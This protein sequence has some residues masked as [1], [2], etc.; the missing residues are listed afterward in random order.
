MAQI[1][2]K[3]AGAQ[4]T[5]SATFVP[6][7][8]AF[9][10]KPLEFNHG[11]GSGVI[12]VVL[13]VPNPLATGANH[14]GIA[15]GLTVNGVLSKM[16]ASFSSETANPGMNARTPTTLVLAV[17]MGPSPV[18]VQAVWRALNGGTASLDS[19]ASLSGLL[20]DGFA[21]EV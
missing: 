12:L 11:P 21:P 6:M 4:T 13:S 20:T 15:F 17:G 7:T 5:T 2:Y 18:H 1:H 10:G 3:E 8:N 16:I 14:P 9:D 19:H